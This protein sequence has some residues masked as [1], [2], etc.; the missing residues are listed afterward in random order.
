MSD[1]TNES[2][3]QTLAARAAELAGRLLALAAEGDG[4]PQRL[5]VS[6]AAIAAVQGVLDTWSASHS[7]DGGGA[8]LP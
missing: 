8:S 6:L 3:E 4:T 5:L 2:E 7:D 1:R